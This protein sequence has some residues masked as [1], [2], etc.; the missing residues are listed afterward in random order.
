MSSIYT[1]KVLR[2]RTKENTASSSLNASTMNN[3]I[4]AG[5]QQLPQRKK[6]LPGTKPDTL[7]RGDV[8]SQQQ[9]YSHNRVSATKKSPP[10]FEGMAQTQQEFFNKQITDNDQNAVDFARNV[11]EM[12]R[13]RYNK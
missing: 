6:F 12:A 8:V 11:A 4:D 1:Q 5:S 10:N 9:Q 13:S 7:N 2:D 3:S